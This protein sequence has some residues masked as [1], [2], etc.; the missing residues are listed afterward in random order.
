MKTNEKYSFINIL[1]SVGFVF[2]RLCRTSVLEPC[3]WN[4]LR[5]AGGGEQNF[6]LLFFYPFLL[7]L[8]ITNRS[9]EMPVELC[10]RL[11]KLVLPAPAHIFS[12]TNR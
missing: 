10:L 5:L 4:L 9:M 8:F 12:C 3:N 1:G 11:R 2:G 6:P 7:I